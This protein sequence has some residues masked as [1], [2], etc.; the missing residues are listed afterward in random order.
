MK[1]YKDAESL[2]DNVEVQEEEY[3]CSWYVSK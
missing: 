3:D 2:F 1:K